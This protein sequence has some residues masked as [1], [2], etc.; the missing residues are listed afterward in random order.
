MLYLAAYVGIGMV[1]GSGITQPG[2]PTPELGPGLGLREAILGL[3]L[4]LALIPS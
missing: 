4:G 1:F 2:P 3:G